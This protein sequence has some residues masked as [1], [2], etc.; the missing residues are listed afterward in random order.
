MK[1]NILN[2]D[3]ILKKIY[4]QRDQDDMENKYILYLV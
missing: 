3:V 2:V 1:V 4:K